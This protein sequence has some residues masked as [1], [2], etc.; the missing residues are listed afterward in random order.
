MAA[1]VSSFMFNPL[2]KSTVMTMDFTW[3]NSEIDEHTG[4]YWIF[5]EA[6]RE[7]FRRHFPLAGWKRSHKHVET[8]FS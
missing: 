1:D 6:L 2:S 5:G 7:E 3:L 8:C 4:S